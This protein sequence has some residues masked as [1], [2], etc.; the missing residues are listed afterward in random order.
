LGTNSVTTVKIT[1]ANVT[2]AK[3]GADAVTAAK[4]ADDAVVDANIDTSGAF[5]LFG[6]WATTDSLSAAFVK[7]EVYA[8]GTDGFVCAIATTNRG[9][10]IGYTDSNSSPTT[11]VMQD[12]SY[13]DAGRG[14]L[15]MPIKKD[16]YWKLTSSHDSLTIR[17]LPIG[18]GSCVKQ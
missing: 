6:T 15:M 3:L 10:I 7:D 5:S 8:A 17:F 1:D 13:F 2:E 9:W 18:T 12:Y 14:G 11:I 4:L 16:D